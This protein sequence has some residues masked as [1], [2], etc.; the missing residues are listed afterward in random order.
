MDFHPNLKIAA[1][2]NDPDFPISQGDDSCHKDRVV[3]AY[4]FYNHDPS[5]KNHSSLVQSPT[6][7]M[8]NNYVFHQRNFYMDDHRLCITSPVLQEIV[9]IQ[10]YKR[11]HKQK[12]QQ[13]VVKC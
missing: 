1:V 7:K 4:L 3:H 6:E 11:Q 2:E 10:A 8:D 13:S 5:I 12:S 9:L